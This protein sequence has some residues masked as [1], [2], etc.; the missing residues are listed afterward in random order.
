MKYLI[1]SRVLFRLLLNL[2]RLLFAPWLLLRRARACPRGGWIALTL[3]GT[4]DDLPPPRMDVWR[5]RLRG[6]A[7]SP[8]LSLYRIGELVTA[9]LADPKPTGVLVVVRD[10]HT[11]AAQRSALQEQL[12]R[13]RSAGRSVVVYLPDGGSSPELAIAAAATKVVLGAKTTLGPL[14]FR[15]GGWY[16]RRALDRA[17]VIPDVHAQGDYKTAGEGLVRNDMSPA[18]REQLGRIVDTWHDDF[19]A[20]LAAGRSVTPDVVR[21][22]IDRGLLSAD[23]AVREGLADATAYDDEVTGILAGNPEKRAHVVDGARYLKRRQ[24]R[25]F[26]RIVRRRRVV[27][28]PIHG[29]IVERSPWSLGRLC[30]AEHVVALLQSL[31][32]DRRVAAVVLHVDSPGGG[33]VASDRIHRAV[34]L[35]AKK[36]PVVACFA[37]VAA[38]GGYYVAAAARAIVARPTTITGSI[39]V[40]A[41]RVVVGPLLERIGVRAERVVR[42]DY[43]DMFD[44]SRPFT[45]AERALFNAELAR[46]YDDFVQLVADGRGRPRDEIL[47]LAGGRVWTGADAL[48]RGLVDQ[49]GGLETALAHTQTL[50]PGPKRPVDTVFVTPSSSGSRPPPWMTAMLAGARMVVPGVDAVATSLALASRERVL[51]YWDGEGSYVGTN[52]QWRAPTKLP[53]GRFSIRK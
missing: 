14:G 37:G 15:A 23:V 46:T 40:V 13:L 11:S 4:L 17:G 41:T 45:E 20:A 39:G 38:S 16:L 3:S 18:Q 7:A 26:R 10:F 33:V 52:A 22:W 32:G 24:I 50:L 53:D 2:L 29:A 47:P 5:R 31:A 30:D 28:V 12:G 51:A 1:R 48:E 34:G 43:V 44:V 21:S 27:V 49:L 35:V 8:T 42:G 25:L 19:V 9:L 36:K 6:E